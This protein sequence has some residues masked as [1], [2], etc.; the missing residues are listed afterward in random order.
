MGLLKPIFLQIFILVLILSPYSSIA[1]F[2]QL[3][4]PIQAPQKSDSFANKRIKAERLTLPFWDDFSGP[5][6]DTNKWIS[7]GATQSTTVA[8]AAPTIGTLLLDGIDEAGR[9]YS[10]VQFEQ[11]LTD[12]ITSFPIDLSGLST[13][14]A[15]SVYLS[16]FWQPGGKAEMPDPNDFLSLQFLD[17]DSLWVNVWEKSGGLTAEE[18][19]FTQETIKVLPKFLHDKFQ[20]RFQIQGRS[21]GPFDSWILDYVFLHKN[22]TET[23]LSFPDRA[24]TLSN[25][26]PFEKYSAI[27]LFILQK[28]QD[29]FW[30]TTSNEFKNLDNGFRAMEYTFEIR[31]KANQNVVKT[32]NSNTPFNPVPV[33][34]ERRTFGSNTISNVPLPDEEMDYELISYLVTGDGLLNGVENGIPIT[35]PEV[36][37]RINDTVRTTL[38]IRDFLAYDDGSVDYSAGINQRSGMLAVRYEVSSTVYLKGISINFTNFTQLGGVIDLMVWKELEEEPIFKKE[39]FIPTKTSLNE[40]AYFEVDQNVAIDGSFYIGFTQFTNDFLYVG[41]DK[42]YDNG[43]EIFFNATGSWVQNE[44]VEGSLMIRAHLLGTP[45][46]ESESEASVPLKIYP[47]PVVGSLLIEGKVDTINVY[48]PMGRN[49]ILPISD[50][51]KGK[52]VNFEGMQSGIYVVKTTIGKEQKSF[53]ILVK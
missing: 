3:P 11:G 41:L 53:R 7:E 39:V 33:G 22:R 28:D 14:E 25:S 13:S 1:Q 17:Q 29:T 35:Y 31:E 9:P 43:G 44:T 2:Q 8:N 51:D 45:P 18:F 10:T 47:N 5:Q 46:F 38:P 42:T 30:N 15:N 6:L 36:D 48:D 4:T 40:F 19:F 34:Q 26:R 23:D 52:N 24:L 37:F 12:K 20:F 27:P 50:Y 32:I 16:F 49:I 21:S